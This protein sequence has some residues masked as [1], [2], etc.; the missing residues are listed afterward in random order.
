MAVRTSRCKYVDFSDD[1]PAV[2]GAGR[3]RIRRWNE[4]IVGCFRSLSV[5]IGVGDGIHVVV[6]DND[7]NGVQFAF[8]LP[9]FFFFFFV[10]TMLSITIPFSEF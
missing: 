2:A 1:D 4:T 10:F 8:H 3:K 9:I 7:D 6:I 5:D